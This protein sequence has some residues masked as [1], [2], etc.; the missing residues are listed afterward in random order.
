MNP[1]QWDKRTMVGGIRIWRKLRRHQ[2]GNATMILAGGIPAL[3]GSAGLAVDVSQ[4]YLWKRELQHSVDQSALSAAYALAENSSNVSYIVRARQEFDANKDI[5][6]TFATT[7]TVVLANFGGGTANSV[8][9]SASASKRLP[10]SGFLMNSAATV[11]VVAQAVFRP[12]ANYQACL[13]ATDEDGTGIDI[14]GN[15]TVDAQCGLAALSCDEDAV[16]IDGSAT[17]LTSSIATCGTASVPPENEGV[18]AE[19]VEGLVDIY[20][21]LVPPDDETPQEYK[22]KSVGTG[23]NKTNLALLEPGTYTGGIDLKCKTMLS[24]GIYVIDGGVLDLSANYDVTGTNVMFV[25][26]NGAR[27]KFGGEGNDNRINL[28]PM[29]ASDFSGTEYASQADAYAGMLV[30][31]TRDNNASNPGHILNGNSNSLMEGNIYLPSSGI[32]ILGTADVAAECLQISARTITIT[33]T[34][35]LKT[36]CPTNETLS[37]GTSRASIRL[38]R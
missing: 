7:P 5:T 29:Q 6:R 9:V 34:A 33:G 11:G 2:G 25:L 30:F 16:V 21:D 15:A 37:A 38:V 8:V 19:N 20:K 13:I 31:E 10:F 17:V 23:K 22:C 27:I 26:K 3:I 1:G 18:V 32:T 36:L 28:T 35:Y 12:G 14:G 24:A 4:W